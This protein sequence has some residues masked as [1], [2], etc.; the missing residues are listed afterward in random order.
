MLKL[1]RI[2]ADDEIMYTPLSPLNIAYQLEIY[3]QCKDESFPINISERLV[4]NNLIPYIYSD[5]GNELFR[6]VYQ[7]DAQEWLI[8]KKSEQVSIGTTNAFISNVVYEKLEQFVEH[9]SYLFSFNNS[10]PIKINIVNE[11]I[12]YKNNV[13]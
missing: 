10:T 13:Y 7:D 1:G 9:F 6:P 11:Y 4:P 5:N 3:E 12:S 8:Y 2:D